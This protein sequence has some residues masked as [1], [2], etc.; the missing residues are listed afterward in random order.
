MQFPKSYSIGLF[1]AVT[2]IALALLVAVYFYM[3]WSP[4]D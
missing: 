4:R 3:Q 2:L 1:A